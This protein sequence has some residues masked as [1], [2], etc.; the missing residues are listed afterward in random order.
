MPGRGASLRGAL[1]EAG[2]WVLA[3]LPWSAVAQLVLL[4]V[5]CRVRSGAWP[6]P[7][8]P[9]VD[10]VALPLQQEVWALS[11]VGA[12]FSVFATPLAVAC[13]AVS[14]RSSLWPAIAVNLLGAAL[15]FL[16]V[17]GDVAR[18]GAWAWD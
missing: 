10:T 4:V 8:V 11:C 1:G 7:W 12:L 14:G 18:F 15:L 9:D 2:T 6:R 13:R 17:R 3:F 16:V 5:T